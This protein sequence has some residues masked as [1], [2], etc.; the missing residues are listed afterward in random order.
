MKWGALRDVTIKIEVAG[1][2]IFVL[3]LLNYV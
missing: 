1:E 3:Y 2:I